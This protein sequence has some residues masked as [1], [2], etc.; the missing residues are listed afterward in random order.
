[1]KERPIIMGAES[2]RAILDGRKSMTRRVVKDQPPSIF[3]H[4]CGNDPKNRLLNAKGER[5]FLFL[6]QPDIG[7]PFSEVFGTQRF[8]DNAFKC[9]Y[10]QVGDHLWVRESWASLGFHEGNVPIHVLK[11]NN[12]IEHDVVYSAECPDFEWLDENGSCEYNKNGTQASHWKSPMFMSRLMSRITLEITDVRVERLQD[13][14]ESDA[15]AEGI[16]DGGCL[17]CGEHEPCGCDNPMP[18]AR[19]A[20]IHLWNTLNAKR[21]Y[22]WESNPWVWVIEFKVVTHA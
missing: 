18:E 9:P 22:P 1:M 3:K 10:G 13:I 2:V 15:R 6:D 19:D 4:V 21:G 7:Y 11:D 8:P 5:V 17:N 16:V 20:Y 12:G 14:T